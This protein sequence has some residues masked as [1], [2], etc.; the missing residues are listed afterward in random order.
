MKYYLLAGRSK[1]R[2][3]YVKGKK[4]KGEK[5]RKKTRRHFYTNYQHI[6]GF[7][8]HWFL[9]FF[10]WHDSEELSPILTNKCLL[11][12]FGYHIAEKCKWYHLSS[13]VPWCHCL[14]SYSMLMS[15]LNKIWSDLYAHHPGMPPHWTRAILSAYPSD[16]AYNVTSPWS[17]PHQWPCPCCTCFL[18]SPVITITIPIANDTNISAEVWYHCPYSCPI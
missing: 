16:N 5:Q 14:Y 3:E 7:P 4:E 17:R 13:E 2:K 9:H 1:E 10:L 12:F 11:L 15:R 8:N 18:D 6:L